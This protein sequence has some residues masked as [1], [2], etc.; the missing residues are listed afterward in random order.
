MISNLADPSVLYYNGKYYLSGTGDTVSYDIY[1]SGDLVNWVKG[2]KIF[3]PAGAINLWAP[4]LFY[5][6]TDGKFYIY[7]AMNYCIGVACS[8][9]PDGIYTDLGCIISNAIDPQMFRD[10]NGSYYLYYSGITTN[11]PTDPVYS[12]IYVQPMSSP[13]NLQGSPTIVLSPDQPWE[14]SVQ[15][16]P[17]LL[18][19]NNTYYLLFSANNTEYVTYAVGYAASSS[20]VGPFVKYGGDPFLKATNNVYGPGSCCVTTDKKGAFWIIYHEK[21]DSGNDWARSICIDS[22]WFDT[23]GVI[24]VNPTRGTAVEAPS[25]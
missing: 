22:L 24:N 20:P 23:N 4:D 19:Y 25:E 10:G 17:W 8:D 5:N 15:E 7:Y 3:T 6:P 1:T 18:K 2:N 14:T 11:F 13:S 12:R 9:T 16:A 21:D